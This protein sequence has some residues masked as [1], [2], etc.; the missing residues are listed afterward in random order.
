MNLNAVRDYLLQALPK[1]GFKIPVMAQGA[2]YLYLDASAFTDNSQD[3]CQRL[4]QAT[5]V[6]LTPGVDFGDQHGQYFVR[7]AYTTRIERLQQAVDRMASWL[8]EESQSTSSS[9]GSSGGVSG[10]ASAGVSAG[11]PESKRNDAQKGAD[12]AV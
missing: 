6:A 4:L 10:D 1:L 9:A 7:V 2:F 11:A 5:G 8:A 3:F 12:H